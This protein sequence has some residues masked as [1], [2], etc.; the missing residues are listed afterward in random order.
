[1]TCGHLPAHFLFVGGGRARG[2]SCWDGVP[3]GAAGAEGL[4]LLFPLQR[5]QEQQRVQARLPQRLHDNPG[6]VGG[7][8]GPCTPQPPPGLR[9]RYL[10]LGW[11]GPPP[12]RPTPHASPAERSAS[13]VPGQPHSCPGNGIAC[14]RQAKAPSRPRL[15]AWRG[16]GTP[17]DGTQRLTPSASLPTE[18]HLSPTRS[19]P[20]GLGHPPPLQ[21]SPFSPPFPGAQGARGGGAG[22]AGAARGSGDPGF[23]GETEGTGGQ[24][25]PARPATPQP[26]EP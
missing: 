24:V 10:A 1:M 21:P 22:G 13:R 25:S 11:A 19:D 3:G 2:G 23:P 20:Q 26:A 6:G 12:T 4:W 17:R 9:P 14:G 8:E 7:R 5:L 15:E 18:Q 16:Q